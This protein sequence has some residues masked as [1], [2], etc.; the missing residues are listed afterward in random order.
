ME[1]QDLVVIGGGPAGYVAAI[2]AAQ[3]DK[4]VTLIEADAVGGTCLNRGCVPTKALLHAAELYAAAKAGEAIGVV[5]KEIIFD[6]ARA[7]AHKE[8][9]V[10]Q[11]REGIETLLRQNRITCIQ[12]RA[13]IV[14]AGAVAVGNQT[15][16]T[17]KILVATGSVPA[18]PPIAGIDSA[19]VVTSDGLLAM[20]RCPESIVI[21]GGGVIGVEFASFYTMLGVAVTILEAEDRIL[22]LFD[23][24][25]SRS[26]AMLL[27]KRGIT[28]V[29]GA[30]VQRIETTT[31]N[32][33]CYTTQ[34]GEDAAVSAAL[35]LVATGRRANTE[36]LF[37]DGVAVNMQRGFVETDADG[38]TSLAG[39]YAAGDVVFGA[40]Q[41]AHAAS[42]MGENAVCA[43][44]GKP[45]PFTMQNIP[46][47]IYTSPEIA[48]VGITE[49]QAKQAGTDV[50]VG[51]YLMGGN[52]RMQIAS[53]ERGFIKLL[54]RADTHV[55]CGAQLLCERATDLID[56]LALAI[57][58][59]L[60][61][62]QVAGIVR[63]HPTFAEG[64]GEAATAAFGSAIHMPPKSHK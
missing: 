26:A 10:S 2:K 15:I 39:V 12:D 49:Q 34:N 57:E 28:I 5:A 17:E 55:L 51:K 45:K 1:K 27:K 42:A 35:V 38:K 63:A 50:V 11:L 59:G 58:Q 29:T 52:A 53:G 60:T 20:N 33:V 13:Q 22:P 18:R 46:A 19:G 47:C 54:F 23:L 36:G 61:D 4:R 40:V 37:A 25:L 41:L 32:T 30:C 56:E 21:I 44:F 3:L 48:S 16:Q 64:I 9:V 43:M 14:G 7:A 6:Y 62:L 24:E 31:Q 8:T